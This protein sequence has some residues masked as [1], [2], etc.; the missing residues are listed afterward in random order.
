MSK[1]LEV[2][3]LKTHFKKG[4]LT[5]RAVDGIDFDINKGETVAL[6]GESGCGKSMTSLLIMGLV[7]SPGGKIKNGQILLNGVDLAQSSEKKMYK[8]RGKDIAMIFQEPMTSLNPVLT[9]GDQLMSV[10]IYHLKLTK[11]QAEKKA[12]EMLDL[13]GTHIGETEKRTADQI[14]RA[15]GSVLFIDEAYTLAGSG[16]NDYG[17]SGRSAAEANIGRQGEFLLIAAGY[18]KEM[19]R[20]D[21]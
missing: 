19:N 2:K 16:E 7:P 14:E 21:S 4:K 12:I 8:V 9:I 15:M 20:F 1:L 17:K 18:Q 10:I 13:V 11:K 6:V 3:N 5:V